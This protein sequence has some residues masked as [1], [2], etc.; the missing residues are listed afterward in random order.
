MN[1][2]EPISLPEARKRIG[3]R[4]GW[5]SLL[6]YLLARELSAGVHFVDRQRGRRRTR[7]R[8]TIAAIRAH[9]PE[10]V[11]GEPKASTPDGIEVNKMREAL[12]LL[13]DKIVDLADERI[14]RR[15]EPK[16]CALSSR[17]HDLEERAFRKL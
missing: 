10:L 5:R 4:K 13:D 3:Y 12:D 6:N 1:D 17:V 14:R 2:H 15:V 9:C 16:I 7:Y 11:P 8:V